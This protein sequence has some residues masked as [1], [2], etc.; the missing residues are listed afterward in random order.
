MDTVAFGENRYIIGIRFK[1]S[2]DFLYYG[3]KIIGWIAQ[4]RYAIQYK[5]A[6]ADTM[7]G[8]LAGQGRYDLYTD[9]NIGVKEDIVFSHISSIKVPKALWNNDLFD[10]NV[11]DYDWIRILKK[12]FKHLEKLRQIK[13]NK[14]K[15]EERQRNRELGI[16]KRIKPK[17]CS[18]CLCRTC[19]LSLINP[20]HEYCD[21]C[22][23]CYDKGNY[24]YRKWKKDNGKP[25]CKKYKEWEKMSK[26]QIFGKGF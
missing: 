15:E 5:K 17:D 4:P 24:V 13:I 8:L 11:E 21:N 26:H 2:R 3:G 10:E 19:R 6:R 23:C 25:E 9:L 20:P 12:H 14:R 7:I 1:D 16:N 22:T 18:R